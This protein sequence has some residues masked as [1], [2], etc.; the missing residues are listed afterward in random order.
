MIVVGDKYRQAFIDK[1]KVR[2]KKD[3]S[4]IPTLGLLLHPYS[5]PCW[6]IMI[7]DE[8]KEDMDAAKCFII[9][10]K[11]SHPSEVI[12]FFEKKENT[13]L[14]DM[15]IFRAMTSSKEHKKYVL[16]IWCTNIES[17]DK[18]HQLRRQN[19]RRLAS[20][21]GTS[22]LEAALCYTQ[23]NKFGIGLRLTLY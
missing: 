13:G 15:K 10:V 9:L 21:Q 22:I 6:T 20:K 17:I 23:L 19:H 4:L 1:L 3:P 2:A 18:D 14:E 5:H 11:S 7:E 8:R 16:N 12:S